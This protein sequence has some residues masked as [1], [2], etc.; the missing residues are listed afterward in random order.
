VI[1]GQRYMGVRSNCEDG[2]KLGLFL[3]LYCTFPL[4]HSFIYFGQNIGV[5]Y[6]LKNNKS[7]VRRIIK[8]LK[9]G[10]T[11]CSS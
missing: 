5:G 9:T 8:E 1:E 4:I 3:L 6:I 11:L 2:V 7:I 10:P